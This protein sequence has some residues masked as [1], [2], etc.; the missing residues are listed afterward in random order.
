MRLRRRTRETHRHERAVVLQELSTPT[1][2]QNRADL[3]ASKAREKR[4][5]LKASEKNS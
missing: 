4:L 5:R 2:A 3:E 1:A